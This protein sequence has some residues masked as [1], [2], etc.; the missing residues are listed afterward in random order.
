VR[1]HTRVVAAAKSGRQVTH[2]ITES[3]S[4][5]EAWAA[6][7]FIDAT[8]DGDFAALAGCGFDIGHPESGRTQPMSLI[9]ILAG[10]HD[11]E[12]EPFLHLGGRPWRADSDRLLAELKF[13]GIEPSY[14]APILMRVH[15]QLLLMMANH[16]YGASALDA[17]QISDATLAA[18]AEV[19]TI[20]NA[21]RS[22]GG[23]WASLR[24]V[25]TAP[26]IGVREGRRI[27]GRYRVTAEDLI[28]GVR[29]HDAV[30]RVTFPVDV[31]SLDGKGDKG[32]SNTGI[33]SKPYDIPL[34][35][36]IAADVDGLYLA[37]RCISG[38]FLAHA[39]YRVTGN[40]V[41]MGEAAGAAAAGVFSG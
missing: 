21:L 10:V 28:N 35:A 34:R 36:L 30:C 12:I 25:A 32:F 26:Q 5:R 14:A 29:H 38:D 33:K 37:G 23:P 17:Q 40:A 16:Q 27:R 8:G 7:S 3:K 13:A 19:N 6:R 15:P 22:R 4:G 9:A 11:T 1:L 2:A 18:R 31:H 39:S 20:V 24:L 41:A